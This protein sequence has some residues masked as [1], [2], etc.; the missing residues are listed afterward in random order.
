MKILYVADNRNRGNYG[1]RATS[2]ALS[3]LVG[4]RH[5]IVGRITGR[6]THY[7]TGNLV[8]C[9]YFPS[10]LY[11]WLGSCRSWNRFR[12]TVHRILHFLTRKR[13]LF[14]PCDFACQDMERMIKNFKKCLPAN[15]Q[16]KEFDIES[17]DFDAMVVNGEGSFIFC[18]PPWRESLVISMCMYWALELGKKVFFMNAMFSDMPNSPKNQKTLDVVNELFSRCEVVVARESISFEY[19]KSNL[20]SVNPILK[21]DA[22]FTWYRFIN[23][24]HHIENGKYYLA[25]SAEK[26]E[27]Y[28][29]QDFTKPYILVS[30]SSSPVIE[31][32]RKQA[33]DAYSNLVNSIKR[34]YSGKVYLIQVCE[35]DDFLNDVASLTKTPIIALETP[36]LAAAKMLANAQVFVSG[37]YHPAIMASQGG[38]PCVFMGSNS[39]KTYSLQNLLCYPDVKE[40]NVIPDDNDIKEMTAKTLQ[41]VKTQRE[42]RKRI[43]ERAYELYLESR[44]MLDLIK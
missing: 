43:K 21:P 24:E 17:Y 11:K 44:T 12:P 2:T 13:Y 10:W 29:N 26:D 5:E 34:S 1:C 25:H 22:L 37:R 35:G 40:Y 6:Y 39:H 3:M 7:D 30:G 18:T 28:F 33:V 14:G 31:K 41:Y 23:D 9:K 36:L 42:V 19:V 4:E 8:F 20:P 38:T 15:N 16:L 27:S 32:N